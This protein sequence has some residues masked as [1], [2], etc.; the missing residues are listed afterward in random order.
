MEDIKII[1]KLRKGAVLTPA[2]FGCLHGIP[3]L[4]VTQGCLFRCAYCYARGYPGSP[5]PGKVYLY[6][7]L[8]QL[9]EDE[10]RRRRANPRWVV[11]NT[12]SDCFQSHPDILDVTY[13]I[14]RVLMS[15]GIGFSFL[16]KGLIPPRFVQMIGRSPDKI[17]PQIGLV[18]A[19]TAYWEK[20]EPGTPTPEERLENIRQLVQAGIRPEVRIDPII[21]FVTDT[22]ARI[23]ELIERLLE[24]QVKRVTLSYLHLRPAILRQLTEE[25]SPVH[26]RL[27]ESLFRNREW[28]EVGSSSQTKLLPKA[29][30]ERGYLR[31]KRVA[32]EAGIEAVI[33]QCKNPDLRGDLCSSGRMKK[34]LEAKT[35]VQLPLFRC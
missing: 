11:L 5:D 12:A 33:C 9:L 26:R 23:R 4:N 22:E 6:V 31:I 20:Y 18:S 15:H 10:L 3:T 13:A 32:E 25:L 8:P 24:S 19:S 2:R 16:T 1:P 27:V 17:F 34:F 14:I 28:K 30:R 7:N 21:P 35:P 29:I